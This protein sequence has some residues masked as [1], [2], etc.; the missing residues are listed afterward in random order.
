[1][2]SRHATLFNRSKTILVVHWKSF[3]QCSI[4]WPAIQIVCVCK[5]TNSVEYS[6]VIYTFRIWFVLFYYLFFISHSRRLSHFSHNDWA[7]SNLLKVALPSSH[8]FDLFNILVFSCICLPMWTVI[9]ERDTC[10]IWV[11]VG[12][13]C[14]E[15]HSSR[16]SCQ[17]HHASGWVFAFFLRRWER[18]TVEVCR[19]EPRWANH[20]IS[21]TWMVREVGLFLLS[22]WPEPNKVLLS[23]TWFCPCRRANRGRD[24]ITARRAAQSLAWTS[25]RWRWW[26]E[27]NR[28]K[29][30]SPSPLPRKAPRTCFSIHVGFA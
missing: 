9:S 28:F 22:A 25:Q 8:N 1:M 2:S 5:S 12:V 16:T 18:K 19:R 23:W 30:I 11:W 27:R 20:N 14:R 17:T 26:M 15:E 4:F 3:D 10:G 7:S 21:I 29:L 6:Y 24:P 13:G